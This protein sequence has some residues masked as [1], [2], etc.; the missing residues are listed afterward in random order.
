[1]LCGRFVWHA[2]VCPLAGGFVPAGTAIADAL[3]ARPVIAKSAISLAPYCGSLVG[4]LTWLSWILLYLAEPTY[5]QVR[6]CSDGQLVVPN[7]S[8]RW[9]IPCIP[10]RHLV[11]GKYHASISCMCIPNLGK[12]FLVR[13]F[14]HT[15]HKL[16]D[17]K[18]SE[19]C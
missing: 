16:L 12:A 13:T 18:G 3:S 19:S 14:C 7:M 6:T 4:T 15:F 17:Q 8:S 2:L 5:V 1:M 10:S 11:G 9:Q